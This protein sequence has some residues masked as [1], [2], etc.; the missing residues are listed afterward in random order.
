MGTQKQ[1]QMG[2]RTLARR[3]AVDACGASDV[4]DA[5]CDVDDAP[6]DDATSLDL[7]PFV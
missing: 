1:T 6:C 2:T 4:D 3:V 7:R 5:P